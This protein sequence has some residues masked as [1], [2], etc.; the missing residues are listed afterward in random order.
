[1]S[2]WRITGV[3]GDWRPTGIL[4]PLERDLR[5]K[6]E[7]AA[8]RLGPLWLLTAGHP[9]PGDPERRICGSLALVLSSF[10]VAFG[11]LRAVPGDWAAEDAKAFA[12][13]GGLQS[14]VDRAR[15]VAAEL[16]LL[17]GDAATPGANLSPVCPTCG[18]VLDLAVLVR[19]ESATWRRVN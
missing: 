17:F 13:L 1:V 11:R 18:A 12:P 2:E 19:A 10:A 8:R 9:L 5:A 14:A 4:S 15:Q 3:A 6:G 16:G 7:E